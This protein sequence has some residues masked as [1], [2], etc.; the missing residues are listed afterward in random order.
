M[1]MKSKVWPGLTKWNNTLTY[2][3][4]QMTMKKSSTPPC[5]LR[6]TCTIGTCGGRSQPIHMARIYSR[7][8][9]LKD[10]KVSP[11][12]LFGKLTKLQQ[13]GNMDKF[14]HD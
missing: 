13:K 6:E 2:I 14:T 9:S 5:I 3:I 12:I 11:R 1:G 7:M 4:L 8:I 10:S